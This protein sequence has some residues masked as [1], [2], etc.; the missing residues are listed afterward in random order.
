MAVT[1]VVQQAELVIRIDPLGEGP[2][3]D[4][5]IG[6]IGVL[7]GI[8]ASLAIDLLIGLEGNRPK[9]LSRLRPVIAGYRSRVIGVT[10]AVSKDTNGGNA[11]KLPASLKMRLTSV[12][13]IF[14][15][16]AVYC[17]KFCFP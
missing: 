6:G 13:N 1:P 17:Q 9:D 16:G 2:V 3:R 14:N 11:T 7:L 10:F 5:L 4:L 12:S 15:R 8:G